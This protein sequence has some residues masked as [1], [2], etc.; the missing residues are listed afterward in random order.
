MNAGH[1][2]ACD[3][4]RLYN[5]TFRHTDH[6]PLLPAEDARQ[7][8]DHALG[9]W[10]G[11]R[12]TRPSTPAEQALA[13]PYGAPQPGGVD[14]VVR[15]TVHYTT[16]SVRHRVVGGIDPDTNPTTEGNPTDE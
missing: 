16:A 12:F 7:A 4:P 5:Y 6:C 11:A 1:C 9:G 2:P 3:G 15:T 10:P 14:G 13:A 8:A